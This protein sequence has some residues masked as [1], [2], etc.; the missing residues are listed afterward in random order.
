MTTGTAS[1]SADQKAM[2]QLLL[3][4]GQSYADL[5]ELLGV[6][7]AE[8]RARARAALRD[9]GG[10]DPD[11]SVALTDYLLG[12]SDPIER[13]DAVRHLRED[14]DDRRLASELAARLR[15]VA[16]KGELPRLPGEPRPRRFLR[17]VPASSAEGAAEGGTGTPGVATRLT[18]R[19]S[20]LVVGLAAAGVLLI[21]AVLGVT[22]AFGG[23]EGPAATAA[24]EEVQEEVTRVALSSPDGGN[25][26][27]EAVFGLTTADTVFVDLDINRLEPAPDNRT[28]VLWLMV[29]PQQGY[30]LTPILVAPNGSFEQRF[31]IPSSILP[32]VA[33]VRF[34][35]VTLA[36][37]ER[38]A[39]DIQ[40]AQQR[41]E[42]ATQLGDFL[43]EVPGETALRG[44]VPV[45]DEVPGEELEDADE[46]AEGP[47]PGIENT[48]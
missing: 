44:E 13:A 38:L 22:G 46:G 21:A 33:R 31:P 19:Q 5:S 16:P 43:I 27:G 25:A 8:V 26:T 48:P 1:L 41:T 37:N 42:E 4:R 14:P 45:T 40:R 9:L 18:P 2:L 11:R 15:E 30:P 28:Y 6:D 36:S 35:E 12:Q 39:R 24:D 23:D 32:L 10:A 3:E 17:R 29:T 47:E 34:V 7:E 20:R